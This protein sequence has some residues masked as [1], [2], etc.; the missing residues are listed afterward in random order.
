MR[1]AVAPG[2][3]LFLLAHH[4]DEV[5]CAGRSA[6]PARRHA[7]RVCG[8]R[9]AG[10]PRPPSPAEGRRVRRLLGLAP[11]ALAQTC[12]CATRRPS[13]TWRIARRRPGAAAGRR[14]GDGRLRAGLR[15][16]APR[17]R[18]DERGRR[19]GAPA[20]PGLRSASSRCT[21]AA[22]PAS[23]AVARAAG[24]DAAATL[25]RAGTRRRRAGA[26]ARAGSRQREPARALARP[27]AGAGPGGG[28]GR[29]SRPAPC[30]PTNYSRPPHA[31][32]LLY[33]LYTRRRFPEFRAAAEALAA[34]P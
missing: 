13:T 8:L 3:A 10:W 26:A 12:A 15:G 1:A 17:P 25:R 16:R 7:V 22:A 33:E 29:P 23:R 24:P 11:G 4:D 32:R 21:G 9:R 28:R 34:G 20:R 5:F 2:A 27:A 18:R 30:P 19:G 14:R 31:G 6:A